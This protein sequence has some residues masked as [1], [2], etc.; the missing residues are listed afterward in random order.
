MRECALFLDIFL[1]DPLGSNWK[2]GKNK[3]EELWQIS[4]LTE[5][6]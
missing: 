2:Q 4:V 1:G 6:G 5:K 3:E